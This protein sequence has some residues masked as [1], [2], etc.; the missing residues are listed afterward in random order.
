MQLFIACKKQK[1]VGR[2]LILKQRTFTQTTKTL[3][4]IFRP[5]ARSVEAQD[6]YQ[7]TFLFVRKN[8]PNNPNAII[9]IEAGAFTTSV[10]MPLRGSCQNILNRVP[11]E[12][13]A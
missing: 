8:K 2:K 6:G 4:S 5:K 7:L 3:S 11:L 12:L 1:L 13:L 10:G 9:N